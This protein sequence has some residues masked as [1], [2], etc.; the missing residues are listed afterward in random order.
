M[1]AGMRRLAR[2]LFVIALGAAFAPYGAAAQGGA[3]VTG[4][5]TNEAGAPIAGA[6]VFIDGMNVGSTANDAG[7]YSFTVA[8]ARAQGQRVTLSARAL[9]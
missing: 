1:E 5:V 3:S 6:S 7:R 9:V 8:P 2:Q 4:R